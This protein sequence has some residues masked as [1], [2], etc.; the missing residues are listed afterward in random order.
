MFARMCDAF[1]PPEVDKRR[2]AARA[3]VEVHKLDIRRARFRDWFFSDSDVAP[4]LRPLPAETNLKERL[5]GS[6]DGVAA[7]LPSDVTHATLAAA[8]N[9]P[10]SAAPAWSPNNLA[11]TPPAQLETS[12]EFQVD[13]PNAVIKEDVGRGPRGTAL[14]RPANKRVLSASPQLGPSA[15]PL[16]LTSNA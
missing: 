4:G 8:E 3:P 5:M 16:A 15:A 2:R 9:L 1:H 13:A 12:S 11:T 7:I 14:S 10:S 6:H